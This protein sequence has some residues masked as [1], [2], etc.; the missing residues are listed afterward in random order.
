MATGLTQFPFPG[1]TPTGAFFNLP[2]KKTGCRFDTSNSTCRACSG[3][4]GNSVGDMASIC[5]LGAG[6]A[7][8]GVEF[9]ADEGAVEEEEGERV[10]CWF[11]GG[12]ADEGGGY[13]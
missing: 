3:L 13:C 5:D 11:I 10:G 7:Y 12:V 4:L 8:V 6:E 2:V 9:E 1:F